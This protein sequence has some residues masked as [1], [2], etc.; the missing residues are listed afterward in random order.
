MIRVCGSTHVTGFRNCW[1]GNED[2][3]PLGGRRDPCA[4]FPQ[5]IRELPP[6]R[7]SFVQCFRQW[8]EA[9]RAKVAKR[10]A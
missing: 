10:K 4:I 6:A 1:C 3:T 8:R 2:T 5:K 9:H 7:P